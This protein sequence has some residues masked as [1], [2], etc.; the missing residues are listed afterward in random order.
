VLLARLT[1]TALILVAVLTSIAL[2]A[3]PRRPAG[4]APALNCEQRHVL[5]L[6]I[7]HADGSLYAE[8]GAEVRIVPDPRGLLRERVYVDNGVYDD[9]WWLAG[10]IREPLACETVGALT[11]TG[12]GYLLDVTVP[13]CR[14]LQP[15]PVTL[16]ADRDVTV[17][18]GACSTPT[19]TPLPTATA[20][21]EPTQTPR[22]VEV[23]ATVLVRDPVLVPYP[24]VVTATPAP[25][26]QQ[27]AGFSSPSAGSPPAAGPAIRPPGTGTGGLLK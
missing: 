25:G 13:G 12:D 16:G 20:T 8:A 1:L 17:R 7:R 4:A 19:A 21:P 9:A 10:R 24:V 3:G 6:E 27:P 11:T 2:V 5:N 14:V 18:L 26:S 15:R 23:V 22:V